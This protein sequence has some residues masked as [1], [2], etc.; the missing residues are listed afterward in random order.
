[1]AEKTIL[2]DKVHPL[3]TDKIGEWEFFR[4]AAIGGKEFATNNLFSHRLED[5]DDLTQREE[6]VYYLNYC[7]LLPDIYNYYIFRETIKRPVDTNLEIFRD[8]CDRRG[9]DISSFIKKAGRY[10]TIY[11][12]VHILV[13]I[14]ETG[15]VTPTVADIKDSGTAP[16]CTLLLPT[17]VKDWSV[18]DA[19]RLRWIIYE[20]EYYRDLDPK[21]EREIE[22]HYKVITTEEWWIEDEDGN[23][24]KFDEEGAKSEGPN[25]LGFIPIFTL[26][27]KEGEDDKVGESMLK[28]IA[29]INRI[30]LNW[31][32]LIDEQIERQTFSQLIVP[33]DGSMDE[34]EER[35]TD[36]LTKISTSVSFT[37]NPESRHPPA[38]IAPTTDTINTIWNLVLD[39]IKEIFRLAGLQGGTSDLYTSKS[40]RQSQMSFKGVD[41]S[42][43]EKS[44]TYQKA[45]NGISKLAYVQLG[46]N[47]EEFEDVKY[48]TQ[49][50]TV[51]L[52]EE[53]DSIIKVLERNFSETLNK[54]LMKDIA[55][56]AITVTPESIKEIIENEIDA[57]DG[58]ILPLTGGPAEEK[59]AGG[60]GNTN[61]KQGDSFQSR[62]KTLKDEVGKQAKATKR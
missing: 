38:F 32:S 30:I 21:I 43:A 7:D 15:K 41:S 53:V 29:Y 19:G 50:N 47:I 46:A 52:A 57:G 49:F 17:Q 22:T 34:D 6:R 10:A 37:F 33:D 23:K 25:G 48:P 54:T 2:K 3:F 55:R 28:D 61:T 51:A 9:T 36:P 35:G 62:D 56:K 5:T 45:E 13:D 31:C 14:P 18:D 44:V 24:V 59:E 11:G 40:G 8:N 16:Y 42:L 60:D 58:I 12:A 39:H 20:Y 4:D 27:N 1:M 26:Y